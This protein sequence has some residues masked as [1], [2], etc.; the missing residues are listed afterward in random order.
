MARKTKEEARQTRTDILSAAIRIFSVRGVSRTTLNDI[1]KEAGVTRGAIYWHFNNKNDLLAALWDQL[2]LPI[3]PIVQASE[4]SDE[5][6]PL[7]RMREALLSL[8]TSLASD[9]TQLQLFR[10][11]HDKCELVEDTGTEHLHRANCHRDGLKRIGT[12]LSNSV[13]RGQ[14]PPDYNIHLAS[15]AAISFID[16]LLAN[17]LMFPTLIRADREIPLLVDELMAML[18]RGFSA[19]SHDSQ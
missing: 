12:V 11:L 2:F 6:D 3:E 9:P 18:R 15:I 13:A 14:L 4:S 5:S 1:A 10:I 17:W 16:G 8:F 19:R 7:G